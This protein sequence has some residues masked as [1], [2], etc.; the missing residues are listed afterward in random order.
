M[1]KRVTDP[2]GLPLPVAKEAQE[3]ICR[4]TVSL[5]TPVPAGETFMLVL[6]TVRAKAL[7]MRDGKFTWATTLIADQSVTYERVVVLPDGAV[8]E[9][10]TPEPAESTG[11]KLVWR[12]TLSAGES[13]TPRVT[14]RL[15]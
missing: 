7:E 1:L 9:K 15:S 13:F 5:G 12:G 3:G 6:E 8:V 11:G 2:L 4:C 10:A 14:Y